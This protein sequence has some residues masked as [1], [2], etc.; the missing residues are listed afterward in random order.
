MKKI[1]Y[2]LLLIV[3]SLGLVACGSGEKK[4]ET[5]S[6]TFRQTGFDD[7]VEKVEKGKILESDKIP[8][9]Q[10]EGKTG[11][12]IAWEITD[13]ST[14]TTDTVVNAKETAK[15]YTLTVI[16]DNGSQPQGME[17][18]FDQTYTVTQPTRQ[19]FDFVKWNNIDTNEEFPATGSWT[20]DK[21]VTIKAEWR[22]QTKK[23]TFKGIDRTNIP[24]GVNYSFTNTDGGL[25]IEL[26]SGTKFVDFAP[27]KGGFV[28]QSWTDSE[29]KY[30]DMSNMTVIEDITVNAAFAEKPA[31]KYVLTF[32]EIG[33]APVS[34]AVDN[35]AEISA[36]DIPA[37]Q[38]KHAGY[39]VVWDFTPAAVVDTDTVIKVKYEAKQFRVYYKVVKSNLEPIADKFGLIFDSGTGMYY[40]IMTYNEAYQ[41]VDEI[42]DNNL[43][44]DYFVNEESNEKVESGN[45][46]LFTKDIILDKITSEKTDQEKANDDNQWS[47]NV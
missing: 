4:P 23:I 44:L 14:I 11:Y 3:M 30:F 10:G 2:L 9:I 32:I 28:F 19:G 35:G 13:F 15:K 34:V 43:K 16:A 21:D 20:I 5:Y 7:I 29:G 25:Y 42:F 40:Q 37:T 8:P 36:S 46:F 38:E 26:V 31:G 39:N 45:Q 18:T 47:E 17:V 12:T 1:I 27:V 22:A 41:I 6:I 24:L 33:Q